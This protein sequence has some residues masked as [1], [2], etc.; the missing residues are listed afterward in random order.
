MKRRGRMILM[1][2][3]CKLRYQVMASRKKLMEIKN[4]L[5]ELHFEEFLYLSDSICTENHN[6]FYKWCQLKNAKRIHA[7]LL[8][9]NINV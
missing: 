2:K 5:K 6:L 1:F 7:C 9:N 3:N 4:E 8:L